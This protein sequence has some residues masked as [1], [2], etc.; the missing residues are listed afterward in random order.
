MPN[1]GGGRPPKLG[2]DQREHLLELLRDGQPWKK[3][4]IQLC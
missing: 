3:Q 2:D 1:F 4:Q